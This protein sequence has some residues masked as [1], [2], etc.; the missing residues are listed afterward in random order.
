MLYLL[1]V[2]AKK[3]DKPIRDHI[4]GREEIRATLLQQLCETNRCRDILRMSPH[5]FVELCTKLRAT[6]HV[7][8]TIH[9][10][11]EEQVARFLYIIGHNVKTITIS[12]FFNRSG[13]TIS[14]NFHAVLRAVISL[15]EEFLQQLFGTTIP[16]EILRSN[17]FY[18]YFKDCIGAID[19]THVRVKVPIADQPRF[20]WEGTASDSKVLKSALSRDDRLKI[21]R[22]KFYL[23]DDGF[24]LKHALITPYRGV[25]YHLKEFA[26]REPEN[27]YELFN[28]RHSS[29]RN[30]IERSFGVLKK[31][32]AIIA[33]GTEPYYDVEVM[34]DIVL[35]CIILHNFLMG[36]DPDQHLIS[37]VDR[38][39]QNNNPEA[40]NEEREEV[41]EDYRR[42]A[43]LRDNMAAQMWADYQIER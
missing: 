17:R 38:E 11:V 42:G 8:D 9:V 43:A 28:L 10:T 3:V 21:P 7:K 26:G 25:R 39:L 33:G 16:S 4:I 13:E 40:T 23:G 35:A 31:R 36:V 29:L 37:Q 14:H 12:F 27:A 34:V 1:K 6:G 24:M 22:G 2:M 32:F 18:P 41:N 19:G 30:V 5:A 20:R 15:E